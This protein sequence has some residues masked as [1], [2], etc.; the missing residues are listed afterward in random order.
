M[1]G[2]HPQIHPLLSLLLPQSICIL[3][4]ALS[5]WSGVSNSF[6][7]G[8]MPGKGHPRGRADWRDD[9]HS[10]Q[11]R[12][13]GRAAWDGHAILIAVVKTQL[14]PHSE[15]SG[16]PS[17]QAG[18]FRELS[19]AGYSDRWARPCKLTWQTW[20]PWQSLTEAKL[21]TGLVQPLPVTYA[22][23]LGFCVSQ[24]CHCLCSGR[25]Q[26]SLAQAVHDHLEDKEVV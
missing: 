14:Q 22:R 1:W 18:G 19:T 8:P 16:S 21:G 7:A 13:V 4:L 10:C 5:T 9:G 15:L 11:R 20:G 17:T 24:L 2:T 3:W 12:N 6:T 25:A 23:H 26:T